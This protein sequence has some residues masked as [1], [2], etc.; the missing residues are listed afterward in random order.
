MRKFHN[1]VCELMIARAELPDDPEAPCFQLVYPRGSLKTTARD[2][3]ISE[4]AIKLVSTLEFSLTD[5]LFGWIEVVILRL[6]YA[7]TYL[8]PTKSHEEWR[9]RGCP[10][11]RLA[12][13]FAFTIQHPNPGNQCFAIPSEV[14]K[15]QDGRYGYNKGSARVWLLWNG[16]GYLLVQGGMTTPPR[17][18]ESYAILTEYRHE[19]SPSAW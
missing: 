8:L 5:W 15:M 17:D 6:F 1:K 4:S 18:Q 12:K 16:A 9:H 3:P 2:C 10:G 7:T 14:F 19:P 11:L 13:L